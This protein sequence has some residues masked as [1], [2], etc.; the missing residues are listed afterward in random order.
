MKSL[1]NMNRIHDNKVI[2]ISEYN[3]LHD[4]LNPSKRTKNIKINYYPILHVFMNT[5]RAIAKF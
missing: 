1:N 4:V 5:C 2:N 3:L